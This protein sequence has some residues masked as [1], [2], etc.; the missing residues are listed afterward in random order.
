MKQIFKLKNFN[1]FTLLLMMIVFTFSACEKDESINT[2]ITADAGADM[3]VAVNQVVTLDGSKSEASEGT[4]SYEWMIDSKPAGSAAMLDDDSAVKPTITPDVVGDYVITLTV[5]NGNAQDSDQVILTA[6][7]GGSDE[8]ESIEGEITENTTWT[9]HIDSPVVPDYILT[10]NTYLSAELTIEPGV[11]IHA[12]EDVVLTVTENGVLMASGTSGEMINMT[13]SNAS[14]GQHWKGI[15]IVSTDIRNEL[16]YVNISYAGN[17][18]FTDFDDYVDTEA[19]IALLDGGVLNINNSIVNNSKG[20]GMY[21]R[22]GEL[23]SFSN[24][25]FEDNAA[26]GIGLMIK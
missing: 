21:I 1:F 23:L 26:N 20:Y 8:T 12:E 15:K 14:G 18:E 11:L 9:N 5:S 7:N 25:I 16:N 19:V 4:L 2:S 3:T 17:S 13:A 24:N 6:T 22:Y 10:G